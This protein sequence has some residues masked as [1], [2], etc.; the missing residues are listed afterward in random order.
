MWIPLWLCE[1]GNSLMLLRCRCVA[2]GLPLPLSLLAV[3]RSAI[4]LGLVS[5]LLVLPR[6]GWLSSRHGSGVQSCL[7]YNDRAGLTTLHHLLLVSNVSLCR[8]WG[9][10]ISEGLT[11][12]LRC[13]LFKPCTGPSNSPS[14]KDFKFKYNYKHNP[15]S[16]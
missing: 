3:S 11:H 10:K 9:K 4:W 15:A 14:W 6:S 12:C 5:H 13:P 7:P 2:L 16:S 1:A 8:S